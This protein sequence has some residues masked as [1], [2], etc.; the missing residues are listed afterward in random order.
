MI[1]S[2]TKTF[3]LDYHSVKELTYNL[4]HTLLNVNPQSTVFLVVLLAVLL[5]L[6]FV[7]AGAEV[8]LF[9]LQGRDLNMLK[10]KQHPAARRI[11]SLMEERKAVYTSLLMAGTFFNISIIILMN[12][13]LNQVL[14]IGTIN[15]FVPVNI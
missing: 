15:L 8:A 3:A 5:L 11:T 10:T 2:F 4:L 14:T 7:S 1:I 6:S 12:Y 9:T 13:L